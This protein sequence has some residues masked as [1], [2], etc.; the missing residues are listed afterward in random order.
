ML[1]PAIRI[2]AKAPNIAK[3]STSVITSFNHKHAKTAIKN[4][5]AFIMTKKM[6]RG[7]YMT[8]IVKQRKHI[9]PDRQRIARRCTFDLSILD[10]KPCFAI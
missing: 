9:V 7:R 10:V 1:K 2:P 3:T 6:L 4:G 5:V 8:A